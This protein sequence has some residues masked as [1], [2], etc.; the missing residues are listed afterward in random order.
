MYR[1]TV[2]MIWDVVGQYSARPM[3][4]CLDPEMY[5]LPNIHGRSLGIQVWHLEAY[6]LQVGSAWL[7]TC[8][9][10]PSWTYLIPLYY[11][12]RFNVDTVSNLRTYSSW[13]CSYTPFY[14][15]MVT[16]WASCIRMIY[17]CMLLDIHAHVWG[18][19]TRSM[20]R[21]WESTV[22]SQTWWLMLGWGHIYPHISMT[23]S[24]PSIPCT[25]VNIYTM[26]LQ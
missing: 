13:G 7:S 10:Q 21:E 12:Y 22:G 26:H 20:V 15:E 6:F 16:R 19:I 3:P 23:D 5:I 8:P 17:I 14:A 9:A 25:Q 11:N 1:E 2:C 4:Y 18:Q 24:I